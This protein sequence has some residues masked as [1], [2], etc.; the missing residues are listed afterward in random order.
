[1][2]M[3]ASLRS[4]WTL[5][6]FAPQ[7]E[8]MSLTRLSWPG[9]SSSAI[10]RFV[11]RPLITRPRV[12][13]RDRMFTSMLPPEIRQTVFLPASG[14]LPNSAAATGV[15]PAPSATSF[16]FSIS[17]RMAAA[18]S[19]SL[20]VTISSTY[21]LTMS[22]V[23]S[24]GVLTAMPSAKVTALSSVSY[25]WSWKACSMLGAPAACTP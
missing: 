21:W 20:T 19:S 5:T 10:I 14:S 1:M 9:L 23:V 7:A 22:N 18:I 13:T 4:W 25:L 6:T 24:P 16:W 12:M 2:A 8:T 17:A 11:L 15:A 3:F